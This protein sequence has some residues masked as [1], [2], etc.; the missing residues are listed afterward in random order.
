MAVP[1][2]RRLAL[3]EWTSPATTPVGERSHVG[4]GY[5]VT[6]DLVL[7]AFH[8]APDDTGSI[9]V[10][11]EDGQPQWREGGRIV[12][13]EESLDAALI[14]VAPPIAPERALHWRAQLLETDV[15][16]QSTAYP[17]AARPDHD[18]GARK[19]AGLRGTLYAQGGGGQGQR[20]LDLGVENPPTMSD[21][22]GISGAPVFIGDDTFVG[23]IRSTGFSGERLQGT[24]AN[25]LLQ[26][27]GFRRA[28]E[29]PWLRRDEPGP[30]VLTLLSE[31]EPGD[32]A[33]S[34][35]ASFLRNGDS[36]ATLMGTSLEDHVV[37]VQ[38]LDA[39][40]T[41]ERWLQL[42]EAICRA[43][44]MIVDV[45]DFQPATMIA[46]GV[47]AVVR[48]GITIAMTARHLA[49]D[50]L[51]R[52][53]F[54]IQESKLVSYDD[55]DL[56]DKDDLHSLNVI[57]NTVV[58]GLRELRSNPRYLD[59]PAYD[60]VR[61]PPQEQPLERQ[62]ARETVLI[63]CS[64]H[65]EYRGHWKK[66]NT[67]LAKSYP[68]NLIARMRDIASPR[69]VGPA[70]YEQIRWTKTCVVDWTHW[71]PNVFFELGVRLACSNL[72]PVCLLEEDDASP[73]LKQKPL[74]EA[75][76]G[77]TRYPASKD[78]RPAVR[79]ALTAHDL[80]RALK[81]GDTPPPRAVSRVP[82]SGTHQV[83]LA[84]FDYAQE[85]VMLRPHEFLRGSVDALVG[86]DPQ[87]TGESPVLFATNPAFARELRHS[88]RERW[89]A[90][91]LY[92]RSRHLKA[93]LD[94]DP[95]L[96]Q[97]L[98][99]LGE[100]FFQQVRADPT[101]PSIKALRD[102]ALLVMDNLDEQPLEKE[103]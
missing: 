48:R 3:V 41:P 12:W 4:T 100:T 73:P 54:N 1:D 14:R 96:R 17:D 20:E 74:L 27:I 66:L 36:I 28:I 53:P 82:Y 102:D 47:R 86:K 18:P 21:W 76:F 44:I 63:L 65:E 25:A 90:S 99:D 80:H 70:L 11:V 29:Q 43:P 52:L 5:F 51:S 16:W 24:P 35:R 68:R 38:V 39:V 32:L 23:I 72:E 97:E 95:A 31:G 34:I 67:A 30:W 64:F 19:S 85:R 10:R 103:T 22:A 37:A 45:T 79:N 59:L 81:D 26:N 60:A 69:L 42:V 91:W 78:V 98:K 6:A 87:K 84:S 71:R 92:L 93:D 83:C 7:T 94:R 75:L 50:E 46:L 56:T 101:D 33:D 89:I 49:D 77:P 62:Q 15:A 40:Q 2:T 55:A 88:V 9:R 58:S 61:C 8:V 13:R 57:A